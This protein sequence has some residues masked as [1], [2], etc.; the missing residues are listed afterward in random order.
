MTIHLSVGNVSILPYSLYHYNW[1]TN[2]TLISYLLNAH[3][4]IV[5]DLFLHLNSNDWTISTLL[6]NYFDIHLSI[7]S[8]G[9][10]V[11]MVTGARIEHGDG[12][13]VWLLVRNKQSQHKAD[14]RRSPVPSEGHPRLRQ[15]AVWHGEGGAYG[16]RKSHPDCSALGAAAPDNVASLQVNN[17]WFSHRV[18][19]VTVISNIFANQYWSCHR[20]VYSAVNLQC[21]W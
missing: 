10:V 20:I 11:T 18:V 1:S 9:C 8:F 4:L 19:L 2:F 13:K 6:V 12:W 21:L 17:F 5:S 14:T 15:R 7:M 16:A 3:F